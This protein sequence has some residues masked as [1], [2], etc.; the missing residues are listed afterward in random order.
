MEGD[1]SYFLSTRG[2]KSTSFLNLYL[3]FHVVSQWTY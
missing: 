1:V 3:L 2:K